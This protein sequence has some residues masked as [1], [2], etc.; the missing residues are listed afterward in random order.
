MANAPFTH[1]TRDGRTLSWF[2][3]NV[4]VCAKCDEIFGSPTAFDAHLARKGGQRAVG[5]AR[6]D[7]S[8]LV[9]NDRGYL[10]TKLYEPGTHA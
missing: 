2:G 3:H 10:V 5:P 9:R 4:C 7:T 6:H 1:T 8:K